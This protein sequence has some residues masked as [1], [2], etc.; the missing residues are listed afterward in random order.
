[1]L[2]EAVSAARVTG[3]GCNPVV[4]RDSPLI[5]VVMRSGRRILRRDRGKTLG[6]IVLAIALL[7]LLFASATAERLN[8]LEAHLSSGDSRIDA[9]V[10]DLSRNSGLL[11]NSDTKDNLGANRSAL[12]TLR[13]DIATIRDTLKDQ[14]EHTRTKDSVSNFLAGGVA[15]LGVLLIGLIA[16][17]IRARIEAEVALRVSEARYRLLVEHASDVI[18]QLD[19]N[20]YREYISPSVTTVFGYQPE[21]LIGLKI[22]K[23]FHPDDAQRVKEAY[24]A[25]S[26]GDDSVTLVARVQPR[27]GGWIWVEARNRLV[28][29]ETGAPAKIIGIMTDIS[30]RHAA[31]TAL[32]ESEENYRSLYAN[33]PAI[34]YTVDT[35][36]KILTATNQALDLFGY[37]R[38]EVIGRK[39]DEFMTRAARQ[40]LP[41]HL[42]P[43]LI[44][45][46]GVV[47]VPGQILTK[48]GDTRD[49]LMSAIAQRDAAGNI[50]RTIVL[51]TDVT[52]RKRLEAA[53]RDSEARAREI[54]E[55]AS[56]VIGRFD[57]SGRC[58]FASPAYSRVFGYDASE[59]LGQEVT[60][61]CIPE[62]IPLVQSTFE[63]MIKHKRPTLITIRGRHKDGRQL[64]L[65]A[66]SSVICDRST[67]AVSEVVSIVRDVT[68]RHLANLRIEEAKREAEQA[69]RAK[70]D[71]LATMSHELRTPMNG[72]LGFTSILL[73]TD[74]N[75]EQR[76]LLA[77][78]QNSGEAL[79]AII[80]D[81]LDLS[82]IEAG[83]LTL[84]DIPFSLREIAYNAV[85]VLEPKAQAKALPL[86]VEIDDDV[87]DA[88]LGDPT[89]LRQ[90]LLNLLSNAV[91]FTESGGVVLRIV[92]IAG[93]DRNVLR[94]EVIDSGM[95]ISQDDQKLLFHPFSQID[96][97]MTRRF[98]GTGL[99]LAI[100]HRLVKAMPGGN[101]GVESELGR[102]SRFWFTAVLPEAEVDGSA[103]ARAEGARHSRPRRILVAEDHLDNQCIIEA[104]LTHTGHSV[105]VVDDGEAAVAAARAGAYDLVLLDVRM[106]GMNG[107]EAARAIRELP[108]RNGRVPIIALSAD[109][110]KSDIDACLAAGMDGHLSKPIEKSTLLQTIDLWS[111]VE[112]EGEASLFI[113]DRKAS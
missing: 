81:I 113:P 32:Q 68:E 56:D 103:F 104:F 112:C 23:Q 78:V 76:L 90:V 12:A 98:G 47:D 45:S 34:I 42:R 60:T 26:R 92:E 8:R 54:A 109:A 15:V 52:E 44:Q 94:F 82:K 17:Q 43:E 86:S 53:L 2:L 30:A 57:A 72:V 33:A 51:V 28:R 40:A 16:G 106:P 14:D 75:P 95:G 65:E 4:V 73:E 50:T 13:A 19:L 84:E 96:N 41:L 69:N 58:T 105:T 101:I 67:G 3:K 70:S 18:F 93:S 66:N 10:S 9:A 74:L 61:A 102:G 71:F 87:R 49:V 55:N 46:G 36:N 100:S 11:A 59:I 27:D 63:G 25:L 83:A 48:A 80:D 88:V 107:L 77:R 35:T 64:W 1:M 97:S 31:E 39:G 89:R 111:A 21:E 20:L 37:T 5:E 110:M 22:T 38:E 91:K 7:L 62:D 24:T 79:L 29:D 99:G 85:N 6:P 108:G